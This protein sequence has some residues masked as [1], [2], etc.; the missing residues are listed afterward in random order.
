MKFTIGAWKLLV[1]FLKTVSVKTKQIFIHAL[2]DSV[3]Q[4]T[5]VPTQYVW[6]DASL[7]N[8]PFLFKNSFKQEN[9]CGYISPKVGLPLIDYI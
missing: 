1:H 4:H 2:A 6:T 9:I 5:G 8:T 7:P 3:L